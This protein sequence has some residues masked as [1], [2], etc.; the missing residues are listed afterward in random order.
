MWLR[1]LTQRGNVERELDREMQ[2]HL[3]MEI[4]Q[5]VRNGMS[6]TEARRQALLA[7]GG[8]ERHKEATRDERGTRWIDDFASD[9]RHA[10]RFFMSRRGFTAT[11]VTTLAIG[12]G[13]ATAVYSLANWILLRPVPGVVASRD[14]VRV[15]LHRIPDTV[16]KWI[17][18]SGMSYTNLRD[19]EAATPA[20][21]ALAAS[22]YGTVHVSSAKLVAT[23]LRSATVAGDY[24]GVLG[25]RPQL[26]RF[27]AAAERGPSASAPVAVISDDLW[28]GKFSADAAIVG[29]TIVVNATTFDIIG[30]APP[31]FRGIDRVGD[32]DLWFPAPMYSVIRHSQ[33][34]FEDRSYTAFSD[35]IGRLAPG[36]TPKSRRRR[37]AKPSRSSR[38][39][40]QTKT[41]S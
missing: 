37:S 34:R 4:E 35:F 10:W 33:A 11:A 30:V 15:D 29:Q 6:V 19:V 8:V 39:R 28:R 13:A 36:A 41:A 14:V 31:K 22:A 25:L 7:F 3:D 23:S 38:R 27:F 17:I 9:S 24:F 2:F 12:I 5:N 21:R 32:L 18:P 1:A 26:G 20:L 16:Q 40:I